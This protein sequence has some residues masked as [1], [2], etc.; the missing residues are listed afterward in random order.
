METGGVTRV[1]VYRLISFGIPIIRKS[2][3][4]FWTFQLIFF[5]RKTAL[6]YR[7]VNALRKLGGNRIKTGG[8]MRVNVYRLISYGIP[9]FR[10]SGKVFF[11]IFGRSNFNFEK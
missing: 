3:K 7:V 9:L 11:A 5:I 8:V 1:I 6:R 10:K 2:S 4:V